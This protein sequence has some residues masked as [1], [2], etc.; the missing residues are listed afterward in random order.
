MYFLNAII[1]GAVGAKLNSFIFK[2]KHNVVLFMVILS[3]LLVYVCF[4]PTRVLQ[5]LAHSV[6]Y[7]FANATPVCDFSQGIWINLSVIQISYTIMAYGLSNGIAYSVH[8]IVLLFSGVVHATPALVDLV[9]L[10]DVISLVYIFTP[11][12]ATLAYL[13]VCVVELSFLVMF[14]FSY[15]VGGLFLMN[16]ANAYTMVLRFRKKK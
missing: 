3:R 8:L 15:T 4:S 5:L 2:G 9:G 11:T 16:A 13:G 10:T 6:Y 12:Y 1:I 7:P 14:D